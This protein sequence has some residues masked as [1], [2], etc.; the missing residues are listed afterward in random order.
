M[1]YNLTGIGKQLNDKEDPANLSGTTTAALSQRGQTTPGIPGL[2]AGT[3]APSLPSQSATTKP[4]VY[5]NGTTDPNPVWYQDIGKAGKAVGSGA[6]GVAKGAYNYVKGAFGQATT[7]PTTQGLTAQDIAGTQHQMGNQFYSQ[8][9]NY[10]G[11]AAPTIS[12]SA[13]AI[14]NQQLQS[15]AGLTAAAN[16]SV[17]SAAD[18]QGQKQA[19][20]DVASQYALAASLGG[21]NAGSALRQASQQAGNLQIND[22]ANAM[23]NRAAEQATARGQLSTATAGLRGQD[24]SEAADNQSAALTQTGLNNTQ[25]QN[26]LANALLAQQG[27]GTSVNANN[28]NAINEQNEQTGLLKDVMGGGGSA[29]MA[30]SDKNTKTDIHSGDETITNFLDKMKPYSWKYKKSVADKPGAGPGKRIGVMAQ[31]LARSKLGKEDI[32]KKDN[33]LL[34]LDGPNALGAALAGLSNLHERLKTI[35]EGKK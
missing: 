14:R 12:S 30:I 21:R 2:P 33:G 4:T 34:R 29:L 8:G 1:G 35:E 32:V 7:N 27:A 9:E 28:A 5:T 10:Q 22:T 19:A 20:T 26:Y 31:D 17:P 18:L 3:S 15:I 6:A 24:L 13:D 23:A 11:Q 25:Q 16:G